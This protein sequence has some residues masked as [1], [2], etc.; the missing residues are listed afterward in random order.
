MGKYKFVIV[1]ISIFVSSIF[2]TYFS[3]WLVQIDA[4]W[5]T[6]QM[7]QQYIVFSFVDWSEF[8]FLA[9]INLRTWLIYL[10]TI[11]FPFF[12]HAFFGQ[13]PSSY[14]LWFISYLSM[15]IAAFTL[16][17]W[18]RLKINDNELFWGLITFIFAGAIITTYIT[19]YIVVIDA[20]WHTS[21]MLFHM[22]FLQMI[23]PSLPVNNYFVLTMFLNWRDFIEHCQGQSSSSYITYFV[24]YLVLYIVI[25]VIIGYI[26]K[27]QYWKKIVENY[28]DEQNLEKSVII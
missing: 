24:G 2:L 11:Y 23:D 13:S 4:L 1:L 8:P 10:S 20:Q 5:H 18:I 17:N 12:E 6:G 25:A 22:N 7:V 26:V 16:I 27:K 3:V 19:V 21:V 14:V 15:L 9:G 28:M